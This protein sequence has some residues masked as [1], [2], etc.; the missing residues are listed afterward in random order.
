MPSGEYLGRTALLAAEVCVAERVPGLHM[1]HLAADMFGSAAVAATLL[2][3]PP[4]VVARMVECP[5][6]SV[7]TGLNLAAAI[8]R[9][10]TLRLPVR[11]P[12]NTFVGNN[13]TLPIDRRGQI[14]V[15]GAADFVLVLPARHLVV[16]R[17]TA[18][19]AEVTI[20]SPA[21]AR[22]TWSAGDLFE[23]GLSLLTFEAGTDRMDVRTA[24]GIKAPVD[25]PGHAN[26][27]VAG[28]LRELDEVPAGASVLLRV[29]TSGDA[30]GSVSLEI[31]PAG[32]NTPALDKRRTPALAGGRR[33]AGAVEASGV[34]GGRH[35]LREVYRRVEDARSAAASAA[36]WLRQ[37]AVQAGH[38]QLEISAARFQ[39]THRIFPV[40][41][42]RE[43][44]AYFAGL[45]MHDLEAARDA[46]LSAARSV[47]KHLR[48]E[49]GALAGSLEDLQQ[50]TSGRIAR[51]ASARSELKALAYRYLK[52][53]RNQTIE[54][55]LG[56]Y[57]A[58]DRSRRGSQTRAEVSA[59]NTSLGPQSAASALKQAVGAVRSAL[60][61]R[62]GRLAAI[63]GSLEP[64][65]TQ[66]A[67]GRGAER[68]WLRVALPL[69]SE[70]IGQ[71]NR[72]LP[73][74]PANNSVIIDRYQNRLCQLVVEGIRNPVYR[75]DP[76]SIGVFGVRPWRGIRG[77]V[78]A[79]AWLAAF[80]RTGFCDEYA[81]LTCATLWDRPDCLGVPITCV[82]A[83]D[84]TGRIH[85]FTLLGPLGHPSSVVVDPWPLVP[86]AVT[87]DRYMIRL[88]AVVA[89]HTLVPDGSNMRA[90]GRAQIRLDRLPASP[91]VVQEVPLWRRASS[92]V[93][94]DHPGIW[95]T[96]HPYRTDGDR[97]GST[98]TLLPSSVDSG[99]HSKGADSALAPR[100]PE[101]IGRLAVPIAGPEL[102]GAEVDAGELIA[103]PTWSLRLTQEVTEHVNV[104]EISR[105]GRGAPQRF[106]DQLVAAADGGHPVVL[107]G[108]PARHEGVDADG[109]NLLNDLLEQFAQRG[110]LPV[111]V[112]REIMVAALLPVARRYG[113]AILYPDS[114]RPGHSV[115]RLD[116]RWKVA[117]PRQDRTVV[118]SSDSWDR[119]TA[120]VLSAARQLARPTDAVSRIDDALGEM[121]WASS[122]Q[123]SREALYRL[124]RRWSPQK[125]KRNLPRVEQ[126]IQR[127]PHSQ[128][129]KIIA[130]VV[131]FAEA[132]HSDLVFDYA[133][134]EEADRPAILLATVA[135][136]EQFARESPV[137]LNGGLTTANLASMVGAV[138][139][140]S[141]T[142]AVT[143][144]LLEVMDDIKNGG[145]GKARSFVDENAGRLDGGQKVQLVNAIGELEAAM[146]ERVS[147]LQILAASVFDCAPKRPAR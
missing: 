123:T 79:M 90:L 102:A 86:A 73:Y 100:H 18:H 116:N 97:I 1:V 52:A 62:R 4:A 67:D 21:T 142:V 75:K 76:N 136:L 121:I 60:D 42:S 122:L 65:I 72:M 108:T 58:T 146:P 5:S 50:Y 101:R 147:Q 12:A 28:L 134:V 49:A 13:R 69:A 10:D 15:R 130:P 43:R 57:E 44:P 8:A 145:L 120:A 37:W 36:G 19:G 53:K 103:P 106:L 30:A 25:R 115:A 125:I 82:M 141:D 91:P 94:V 143:R 63:A 35:S 77:S 6:S 64:H 41:P 93:G 80:F 26:S 118:T 74:G 112:S 113:A 109:V 31:R 32:G 56:Y 99:E 66:I 47:Q 39:E 117:A 9:A 45:T 2:A 54:A 27:G 59:L 132:G 17:A 111:V 38:P 48:E 78:A 95:H 84:D 105:G 46:V 22:P 87:L 92:V 133:A 24:P 40:E 23:A 70:V 20:A 140:S 119:I 83:N 89:A 138:G 55:V 16:E 124:Q 126:M 107:L 144:S 34:P 139:G 14:V 128:S 98:T 81:A 114:E 3:Q 29:A 61:A 96:L 135:R 33:S 7:A 51:S 127:V 137:L 11:M 88:D 85:V 131:E 129:L 68:E 71:V 104:Y 110:Q